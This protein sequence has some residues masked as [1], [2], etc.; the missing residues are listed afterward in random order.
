MNQGVGGP[1]GVAGYGW[2]EQT[3]D[4]DAIIDTV[5]GQARR[6]GRLGGGNPVRMSEPEE[7]N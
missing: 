5:T 6:R 4:A 7:D 2:R 3:V 1:A